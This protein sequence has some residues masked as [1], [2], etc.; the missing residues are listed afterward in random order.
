MLEPI[1]GL[2]VALA[3][4]TIPGRAD[5][6]NVDCD[7]GRSLPLP[8]SYCE[9]SLQLLQTQRI[10][11]TMPIPHLLIL[12]LHPGQLGRCI[13]LQRPQHVVSPGGDHPE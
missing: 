8:R 1:D 3:S 7:L 2:Q 13:L 10:I 4:G 9:V 11:V 5:V 6:V 12:S